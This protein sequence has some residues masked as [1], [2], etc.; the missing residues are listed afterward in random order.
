MY[1]ICFIFTLTLLI[2]NCMFGMYIEGL[3]STEQEE[4]STYIIRD[5]SELIQH[6]WISQQKQFNFYNE[7]LDDELTNILKSIVQFIDALESVTLEK[8]KSTRKDIANLHKKLLTSQFLTNLNAFLNEIVLQYLK[9]NE[10]EEM[11]PI[12][13]I[14]LQIQ[15][16]FSQVFSE[17]IQNIIKEKQPSIPFK[18]SHIKMFNGVKRLQFLTE[19]ISPK[20]C[21]SKEE[22]TKSK[23]HLRCLENL[24]EISLKIQNEFPLQNTIHFPISY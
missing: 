3:I 7:F 5:I 18:P 2:K 12:I 8:I 20:I 19:L 11:N 4:P 13:A 6:T 14:N 9:L 21:T 23:H 1:K 15:N 22:M 10:L 17:K 16:C 24:K